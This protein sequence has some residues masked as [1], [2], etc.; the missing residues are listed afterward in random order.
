MKITQDVRDY[1]A[2]L[3]MKPEDALKDMKQAGMAEKS[4]E[5]RVGGAQVYKKV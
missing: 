2:K 3:N 5:F 4:T 1:A